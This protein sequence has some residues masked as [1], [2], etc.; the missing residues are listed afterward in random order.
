[1]SFKKIVQLV[2]GLAFG[3]TGTPHVSI[4]RYH[5]DFGRRFFTRS[6]TDADG[7]IDQRQ[8]VVFLKE[9]HHSIRQLYTARLLWLELMQ[10]RNGNFLPRCGRTG[11][12][13]GGCLWDFWRNGLPS[14]GSGVKR[15]RVHCEN[16]CYEEQEFY[17]VHFCSPL[18]GSVGFGFSASVSMVATVRLSSRNVLLA[19]R[20]IS[21]LVTLS[22]SS[23]WRKSSRQSP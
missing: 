17:L 16:Y 21:A 11:R 13:R 12:R 10:R 14:L 19:T 4:E 9:N 15:Q 2:T 20:R 5:T 1:M 22:I 7:A 3:A 18:A 8:L 6:A 23:I